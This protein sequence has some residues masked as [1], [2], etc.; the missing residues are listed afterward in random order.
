MDDADHETGVG[1]DTDRGKP[2]STV[3][4][5]AASG[6]PTQVLE[7]LV[8]AVDGQQGGSLPAFVHALQEGYV[9]TDAAGRPVTWN[10]AA[11]RLLNPVEGR[12]FAERF[13]AADRPHI[14]RALQE[15]TTPGTQHLPVLRLAR[16]GADD[17]P[18]RARVWIH[19]PAP[20][21]Q[22]HWLLRQDERGPTGGYLDV[23]A[24]AVAVYACR[25]GDVWSCVAGNGRLEELTGYRL[26]DWLHDGTL[27]LTQVHPEDRD[28]LVSERLRLAAGHPMSV[29]YRMFRQDGTLIWVHDLAVLDEVAD[30]RHIARGV[31]VD[32]TWW[33]R[34]HEVV[35]QLHRGMR[36]DLE[37]LRQREEVREVFEGMLAHDLRGA[38]AVTEGMLT[39]V[40]EYGERLEDD[41]RLE[42]VQRALANAQRGMHVLDDVLEVDRLRQRERRG[43]HPVAPL[44]DVLGPVVSDDVSWADRVR[45]EASSVP[46]QVE[47]GIVHRILDNLVS[48]AARHT[49]GAIVVRADREEDGVHV[50]V[51]DDGPGIP[52]DL[53]DH[54]FDPYV[55]LEGDDAGIGLGL[56]LVRRL[57]EIHGGRVWV[58]N[59]PA[60]GACFHVLLAERG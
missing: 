54:V 53:V 30:E 35:Q 29:Q 41:K 17:R 33:R 9:L 40:L 16:R 48:N 39:T 45:V 31:L 18:T 19:V 23:E 12:S 28:R 21:G 34:S 46:V 47:A 20:G 14:E 51:S 50:T 5:A 32:V 7:S 24:L 13:D 4:G 10:A 58:E 56:Y 52:E 44:A 42:L 57:A 11:E 59:L 27:W 55:R 60:G 3:E 36:A 8:A 43:V 2:A 26:D 38:L 25:L 37:R 22:A 1:R 15:V 49:Q 6:D